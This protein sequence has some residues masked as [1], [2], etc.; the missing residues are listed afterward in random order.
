[1]P[2]IWYET[3][4]RTIIEAYA[5]GTPVIASRLGAMQEIVDDGH[6][7]LLFDPG[8]VDDLTDKINKML[9]KIDGHIEFG[10]NAREQFEL[11]YSPEPAYQSL[12][13]I[14]FR[15]LSP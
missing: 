2:S 5:T 1:M 4:G 15:L 8:N 12:M 7:G 6:T 11:K 14:Y 13:E 3:F 10:R 9:I